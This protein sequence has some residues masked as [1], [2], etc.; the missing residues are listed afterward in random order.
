VINERFLLTAAHCFLQY[1]KASTWRAV[2]GD[3]DFTQQEGAEVWINVEKLIIHEGYD[4]YYSRND[5]ALIKLAKPLHDLPTSDLS[6]T[7]FVC[8][9]PTTILLE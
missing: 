3:H 4:P 9:M 7:R 6:S 1:D 5:I 8:R 2:L